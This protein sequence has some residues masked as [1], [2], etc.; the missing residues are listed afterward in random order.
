MKP[1]YDSLINA[2]LSKKKSQKFQD[3]KIKKCR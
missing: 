2:G 1:D 3:A